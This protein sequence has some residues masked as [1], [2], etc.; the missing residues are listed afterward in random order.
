[1]EDD[2]RDR[3]EESHQRFGR[4]YQE[5]DLGRD[6]VK[7]SRGG[8][9]YAPYTSGGGGGH[10]DGWRD[11]EGGRDRVNRETRLFVANLSWGV[12]WQSL[13]D[14]MRKAG[15]V[16]KCDVFKNPDGSSRVGLK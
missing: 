9:R 14:H 2:E 8:R 4:D 5:R 11:E 3:N 1:M 10:R 12:T 13:K 16:A 7:S 6:S 15:P